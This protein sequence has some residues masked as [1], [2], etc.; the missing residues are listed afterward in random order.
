MKDISKPLLAIVFLLSFSCGDD[1]KCEN[2]S[3]STL[4]FNYSG[5]LNDTFSV[6]GELPSSESTII[7]QHNWAVGE[8]FSDFGKE[9]M[10]INA[11]LLLNKG[12]SHI[13]QIHVPNTGVGKYS[14]PGRNDII[15]F[16]HWKISEPELF[17]E[18]LSG[19]VNVTYSECGRIKGS[20]TGIMKD[21]NGPDTI[22]IT[23]G[24]FDVKTKPH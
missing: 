23:D 16:N 4:S 6:S 10:S 21:A 11:N 7:W 5:F 12:G 8:Y 15:T 9:W 3:K 14:I 17:Y 24:E 19:E 1:D 13:F 18:F 2:F 22:E 20:F